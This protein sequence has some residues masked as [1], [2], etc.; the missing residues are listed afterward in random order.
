M[1]KQYSLVVLLLI[2][3][4]ENSSTDTSLLGGGLLLAVLVSGL[5]GLGEAL[6]TSEPGGLGDL[7]GVG[8]DGLVH[9]L[10]SRLNGVAVNAVGEVDR[11]MTLVLLLIVVKHL[12]HVLGDVLAHDPGDVGLG[13][14]GLGV[15]GVPGEPLV[16]VG[17]VEAAVAGSLEGAEHASTGGGV[18]DADIKESSERASLLVNL[19]HI[20]SA[21]VVLARHDISVN[22]LN[23]RVQ[24]VHAELLQ[25][26]A[27]QEQTSAVGSGVV[28][29]AGGK[30]VLEELLGVGRAEHVVALDLGGDDLAENISVGEADD[31]TV[32]GGF[33]LV[34]VLGDQFV[35]LTVVGLSLCKMKQI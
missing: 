5:D 4:G 31:E 18:L 27:S 25:Q 6:V 10:Q 33:V 21:A 23:T 3:L 29:K 24:L 11:E 8:A 15:L 2:I 16:V 19:L 9:L 28:L 17:D 26:A 34:L 20:V 35:T 32:L 30:A 13:V 14:E 22:I 7:L 12:S 1:S